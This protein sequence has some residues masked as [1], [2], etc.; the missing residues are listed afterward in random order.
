MLTRPFKST[1]KLQL[2]Y[3]FLLTYLVVL[4]FAADSITFATAFNDGITSGLFLTVTWLCYGLLYM[5]PAIAITYLAWLL[6][7]RVTKSAR[8]VTIIV[9]V[10]AVVVGGF[11]TLLFYANAK[12]FSLYGMFINGFILNLLMTPGGIESLGGSSQS[13]IG[14]ALIAGGFLLLQALLL[15]IAYWI[16]KRTSLLEK[17][18]GKTGLYSLIAA[19]VICISVHLIYAAD[20]FNKSRLAPFAES[21]PFFHPVSAGH[22]FSMLGFQANKSQKLNIKGHLHYPLNPILFKQ[23]AKPYNIVWLTSESLR[24]D[25]LDAEIMPAT[26]QFSQKANRFTRNYSGGNGT[27]MGVFSMFMGIPGNYWFQFMR[28][29]RGPAMIDVLQKQGYQMDLF[30]SAKFSYPEFDKTIFSQIP[31]AQLH[32]LSEGGK[33]WERDRTNVS[34]LLDFIDKRDPT[35]PFFTFMFFESPHARYDFPPES[36]I[37]QP[38]RDDINYATLS[39]KELRTDIV[40][41]KNR[42]IN[43]VHHL[44]SQFQRIFTYLQ[45]KNLLDNTIVVVVGDHGEEFME[46]GFWG[47]N[48][49]FVDQQVRTPLVIWVPGKAPR[50]SDEMTSHMDIV[51]TIMPLLGVT[52]PIS[53]Y[54]TGYDLFSPQQR[55]STYI[56]DWSRVTYVDKDVKIT[57]PVSIQGYAG[58][59][60]TTASDEL[61]S[62]DQINAVMETKQS[63]MLD[64]IKDLTKFLDKHSS[65]K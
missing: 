18:P 39:K 4:G 17:L 1:Q 20:T 13:D 36:V 38:Y 34:Q 22:F 46:H 47:H 49:T 8:L 29:E 12:V 32:S 23:P 26:W 5:L 19:L 63:A 62:G 61:I 7:V 31:P 59:H 21:V 35:K 48:S 53:D 55:S 56:S 27:R 65:P 57:Q 45:E 3:Y 50:V 16:A 15:W 30:T 9:N 25:M 44:D 14:F 51:P 40:P 41:I 64:T 2:A 60:I 28:E 58:K 6:S 52:N 37:R 42:Y 24:A 33:S 43:A 11:S 10:V 54:A